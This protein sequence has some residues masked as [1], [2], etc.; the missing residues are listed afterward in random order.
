MARSKCNKH[1]DNADNIL[2]IQPEKTIFDHV[3]KKWSSFFGNDNDLVL[4]LACGR[5]EYTIGLAP[6]FPGK[7]FIGVDLKGPRLRYGAEKAKA[8]W[9]QNVA[10]LRI[11]IQ[12]LDQFFDAKSVDEIRIIHPD[13]RPKNA[14]ARR[15]LSH[16]RF[17]AMYKK[18]LK[19][20]GTLRLKTDDADLFDYSIQMLEQE[21]WT[22]SDQTKDLYH[23][24][25]LAEHFG[26]VTD[27]EYYFHQQGRDICYLK[28]M[29]RNT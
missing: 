23:S 27:Y 6:H 14:D 5:G 22:I 16:P 18:M 29:P 19:A 21:W 12:H 3:K 15:R 25:L 24:S 26:I 2:V 28:A 17:L 20:D 11:I 10:F 7:N 4:E 1:Y 9:L 13:P 8:L